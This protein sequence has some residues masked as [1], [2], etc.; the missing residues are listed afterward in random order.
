MTSH[1]EMETE[2]LADNLAAVTA[3]VN[4]HLEKVGC[5]MKAQMQIEL[6]VEE[7]FVNI[8]SYA[9]AP[10]TGRAIIQ[11]EVTDAPASATIIFIDQGTPYDP[12]AK[13]DPDVSLS[14]KEREI[15]GLGIY[16]T[17]KTMDDVRYEYKDG[18]NILTLMKKI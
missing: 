8:A 7:I 12:L 5:P 18:K 9:Y 10:G 3:F 13:P 11:V 14:A 15:G 2:A 17:K 16:L 6:A 4:G 1:F